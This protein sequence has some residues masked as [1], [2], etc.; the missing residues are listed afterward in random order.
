MIRFYRRYH[1]LLG[2]LLPA[3]VG[4]RPDPADPRSACRGRLRPLPAAPLRV[5]LLDRAGRRLQSFAPGGGAG[6]RRQGTRR[7]ATHSQQPAR[8]RQSD[9]HSTRRVHV[10]R[11][12]AFEDLQLET[13]RKEA[14]IPVDQPGRRVL[15]LVN[16]RG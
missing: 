7:A 16:P 11:G 12:M 4:A 13:G 8:N 2:K 3:L 6:G 15:Y 1:S 10:D 5:A 14:V 9:G